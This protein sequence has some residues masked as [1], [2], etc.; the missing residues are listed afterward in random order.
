MRLSVLSSTSAIVLV[1]TTS[2]QA[3]L[4]VEK[5][6]THP[7]TGHFYLLLEPSNWFEAEAAATSMGGHLVTINS[8]AERNWIRSG[9]QSCGVPLWIGLT[10][11]VQEGSFRWISGEPVGYQGWKPNE[12]N[13]YGGNEDHVIQDW[14]GGWNDMDGTSGSAGS[15]PCT[16]SPIRGL[17]ELTKPTLLA[18]PSAISLLK[19]GVQD[20]QFDGSESL[21]GSIYWVLGSMSANASFSVGYVSVPLATDPYFQF[22]ASHVNSSLLQQSLGLLDEQGDGAATIAVP[23]GNNLLQE[24][25]QLYHSVVIFD[26]QTLGV[27]AAS[28]LAGLQLDSSTASM[29]VNHDLSHVLLLKSKTLAPIPG[30]TTGTVDAAV[31]SVSVAEDGQGGTFEPVSFQIE[32]RGLSPLDIPVAV[33]LGDHSLPLY[34]LQGVLP[35]ATAKGSVNM[36]LPLAGGSGCGAAVQET[37]SVC[38]DLPEDQ[39]LGNNS[40]AAP[41]AITMPW[42]DLR[43]DILDEPGS[44]H[45]GSWI[46]Y[47][48]RVSNA[49][50]VASVPLPGITAITPDGGL[51]NWNQSLH[52]E[53]FWI[54]T[55]P[56]GESVEIPIAPYP[57]LDSAWCGVFQH[58]KAMLG[59]YWWDACSAGNFDEEEIWIDCP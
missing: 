54:P 18:Q 40:L 13:N 49:G 58:L 36:Y 41:I 19:G 6:L 3:E 35:G 11:Q 8:E 50:T 30:K 34:W 17:V 45:P 25:I 59:E 57:V 29:S 48:I 37:I 44:A 15:F 33:S 38:V 39:V 55:I 16:G 52:T 12:P 20:L 22:T 46:S 10:D 23:E 4:S 31:V 26:P 9:F 2:T 21:A 28:D 14:G 51:Q 32:N 1:L 56:A 5:T 24:G 27:V 53:E 42:W 7:G 43:L 47:K